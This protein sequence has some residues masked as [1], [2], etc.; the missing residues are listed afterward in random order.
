[1]LH[2]RY[3]ATLRVVEYRQN[4]RVGGR[5]PFKIH[6]L[7]L[8]AS[9]GNGL[10]NYTTNLRFLASSVLAGAWDQPSLADRLNRALCGGPPNPAQ[11]AARIWFRFDNGQPP[12]QRRLLDFL[13]N[14]PSLYRRF[15]AANAKPLNLVLDPHHMGKPPERLIT[16]PVPSLAT[17]KKLAQWLGL[18]DHELDW[19]A[20][21]PGRQQQIHEPKLHHYRYHWIE[22]RSGELRLLESPKPRL[23][24]IQ[25]QILSEILNS[26]P[27]HPCAYGFCRGRSIHNFIEPHLGRAVLLR[28]DLRDFF[29][30]VP[31]ARIGALFRHLGYPATIAGLL[32]GLCTHASS[33]TLA[34]EFFG[35]LSWTQRKRLTT[36]HLPQGAPS[37]P[38]LA[39]L[40]AWRF[41]CR[42]QGLAE[43]YQLNYS[44]YA[45]DI[46]LSG[47]RH[48]LH[49]A[50]FLQ[51][52]IGAISLEEGFEIN[53][54]KTR[55]RTQAQSQ[56]LAGTVINQK[57]NLPRTEFDQLKAILHN[58]IHQGTENQNRHDHT[59]FKAHLAGRIAY[60]KWLNPVKGEKL[61]RLW[62]QIEWPN[63]H[64]DND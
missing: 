41:D 61:H 15:T 28:M 22:K 4:E 33:R 58:C 48:L 51:D 54:H 29:H 52:L 45:D 2:G 19:F 46:A 7:I 47:D 20:D 9:L 42:L 18:L 24:A 1:M 59:D 8:F 21:Q 49:L 60:V 12:S 44:R 16:L 10:S 43:R 14:E 37:S 55:V 32:Q 63:E 26:V 39:N 3:G 57:P 34:G 13:A 53:H 25:R 6:P 31:V 36:K 23:K 40:C 38:A 62:K 30:S 27:P 35:Q 50:P 11:L 56:R 5:S 17:G 64:T